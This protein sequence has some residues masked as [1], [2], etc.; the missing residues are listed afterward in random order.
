MLSTEISGTSNYQGLAE[1]IRL[2]RSFYLNSLNLPSIRDFAVKSSMSAAGPSVNNLFT[3]L[4][5]HLKYVPDPVGAELIQS[6]SVMVGQINKQG[7]TAGDCDDFASLA[8]TLL[9]LVGIRASLA[10]AWYGD[11][12]NPSHIFVVVPMQDGSLL[13]FDLVAPSL[14]ITKQGVSK[15]SVYA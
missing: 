2:I 7:W 6:P 15:W 14:G 5:S 12:P 11:N 8:Y 13:P 9:N 4:R 1:K 10:V 3:R